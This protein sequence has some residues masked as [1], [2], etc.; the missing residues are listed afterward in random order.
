L[1]R[2]GGVGVTLLASG[3]LGTLLSSCTASVAPAAAPMAEAAPASESAA[4][5]DLELAL[6]AGAS[7]A[8]ILPGGETRVWR[9]AGEVLSGDPAGLQTLPDSYLGPII[10]TAQGQRVRIRFHNEL[11][12]ESI[13]HWHGM[14][15]PHEMDGHPQDVVGPGETY[16]YEFDVQNR[17]GTY[18]F[19]PHPHGRTGPQVY[20]GLAGLLLV[21]D[22]EE[23]ALN[24]PGGEYD[25]PLVIQDRLFDAE[26]QFVYPAGDVTGDADPQSGRGMGGGMMGGMRGGRMQRGRGNMHQGM[27][28]QMMGM[29]GDRILVNGKPDA[30][31][32]VANRA[33]RLRLLNG[34]NARIYKL[35]WSDGTPLTVIASDGGLLERPVQ[36]PYVM[37]APGERVELWADFSPYAVGT[38][39]QLQSQ[40]FSGVEMGGMMG[41]MG[42]SGLPNGAPFPVLTVNV[43]REAEQN[44]TL[45]ERLSAIERLR[46]DEA[47]NAE[48][49]YQIALLMQQMTWTLNGRTF[50]MHGVAQE[51]QVQLGDL[52]LW[53]FANLPGQGM[54]ADF[55]A[56][57]M[58]IH[59]VQFQVVERE[60]DPNYRAGWESVR[61]GYMDE[62]WKDTVL[63]MPGER[64]RVIM[65]F[66]QPGLFL[67]HCHNL[68]HEDMGMMRNYLVTNAV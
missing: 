9:Y 65:R 41:M 39:L 44:A 46:A 17:A 52:V 11:A 55:M 58:H 64:V 40:A 16:S 28:A 23:A 30:S 25:I 8:S 60:V 38:Q 20:N 2:L 13:I 49:P 54:M 4:P 22:P 35:G 62:G 3:G 29:L 36:K 51:E 31:L 7:T 34:S 45:P 27:M 14:I 43:E 5:A 50:D 68:E 67:Y 53:E 57:P 26:N 61:A 18:W 56:H 10:R 42:N 1:L 47:A 6:T 24:L 12:E 21:S 66:T 59:G 32:S 48:N 37:L 63:V 33:Y 19:H 15:V